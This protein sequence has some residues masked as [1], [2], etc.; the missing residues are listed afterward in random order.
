MGTN[1]KT[2]SRANGRT[3]AGR[4]V[5]GWLPTHVGRIFVELDNRAA[6]TPPPRTVFNRISQVGP[7]LDRWAANRPLYDA[8]PSA[9][10]DRDVRATY[11]WEPNSRVRL[12]ARAS[13]SSALPRIAIRHSSKAAT[14]QIGKPPLNGRKAPGGRHGRVRHH[15]CGEPFA[16]RLYQFCLLL[17]DSP[18]F[19]RLQ[20]Y[21]Q[22]VD[23]VVDR[24]ATR[25]GASHSR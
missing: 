6:V 15:D 23:E 3:T 14:P 22:F 11:R 12:S 20:A 2:I 21:R 1:R 4:K 5:G 19:A 13:S 18:F 24:R 10:T 16:R 8:S 9:P 7:V 25:G 17:S